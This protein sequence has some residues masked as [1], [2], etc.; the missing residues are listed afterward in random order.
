MSVD[1]KGKGKERAVPEDYPVDD[2]HWHPARDSDRWTATTIWKESRRRAQAN[3]DSWDYSEFIPATRVTLAD[4]QVLSS[5]VAGGI[6]GCVVS[7]S[8]VTPQL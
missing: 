5:G 2:G 7:L 6:A 8:S 3:K 4:S 1:S